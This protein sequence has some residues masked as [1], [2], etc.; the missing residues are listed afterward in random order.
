MLYGVPWTCFHTDF[1]PKI[2]FL[3]YLVQRDFQFFLETFEVM[4][5]VN[6]NN[7][8][9][10]TNSGGIF[11]LRWIPPSAFILPFCV[12]KQGN[13]IILTQFL[14]RLTPL[15]GN[16][17]SR[18]IV[19]HLNWG[20]VWSLP[21]CWRGNIKMTG[22]MRQNAVWIRSSRLFLKSFVEGIT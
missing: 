16:S 14:L 17:S 22:T 10:P 11:Y 20:T 3:V 21:L 19:M 12:Q 4:T 1:L 15:Y 18:V 7:V 9:K 8:F 5:V 6:H 2:G 13:C